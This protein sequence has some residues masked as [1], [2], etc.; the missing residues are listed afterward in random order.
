[1]NNSQIATWNN[2][3]SIHHSEYK[4]NFLKTNKYIMI[5][6]LKDT[7]VFPNENEWWG[8]YADG[9][10]EKILKVTDTVEYKQDLF[11][12]QTADKAGKI[13]LQTD[14]KG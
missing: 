6:A 9:G 4:T 3:G 8:G 2:E 1:M 10:F 12:L 14:N 5:K 13:K 7:M 11:G